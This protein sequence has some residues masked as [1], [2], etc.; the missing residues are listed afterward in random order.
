MGAMGEST[1]LETNPLLKSNGTT[2]SNQ[3]SDY[4]SASL[5]TIPLASHDDDEELGK[6]E[7]ILSQSSHAGK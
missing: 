6:D 3:T 2:N 4:E 5:T 7:S 1:A